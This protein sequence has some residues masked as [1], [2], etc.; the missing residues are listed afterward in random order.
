MVTQTG[1]SDGC[2]RVRRW[3]KVRPL[4]PGLVQKSKNNK[5]E[6][7]WV[8][9]DLMGTN[10][11][12]NQFD[13]SIKLLKKLKLNSNYPTDKLFRARENLIGTFDQ[14]YSDRWKLR[15]LKMSS[16]KVINH[17]ASTDA[18]DRPRESGLKG[19]ASS[20]RPLHEQI[21][22]LCLGGD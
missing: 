12:K 17:S 6:E 1:N 2:G 16:N 15:I 8:L 21:W 18:D 14:F 10:E 5:I 4:W 9:H 7:L 20:F 22:S 19:W 13:K 3:M 11:M